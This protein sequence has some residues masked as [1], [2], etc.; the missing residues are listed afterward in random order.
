[1]LPLLESLN[2]EKN[3]NTITIGII[4][5]IDHVAIN[6]IVNGFSEHLKAG[7]ATPFK[8]KIKIEN[9]QNDMNLQ[10]VQLSKKMKNANYDVIVPNWYNFATQ[11]TVNQTQTP[12][13]NH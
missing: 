12:V 1:M 5:P 9:A 13:N 7:N 3:S 6:E 8:I 11:M 2:R 10:L 4:E